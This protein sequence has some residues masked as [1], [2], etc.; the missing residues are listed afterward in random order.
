MPTPLPSSCAALL[1]RLPVR[2]LPVSVPVI[3]FEGAR[4]AAGDAVRRHARDITALGQPDH[5]GRA[6][7]HGQCPQG[8]MDGVDRAAGAQHGRAQLVHGRIGRVADD[9][10]LNVADAVQVAHPAC[11]RSARLDQ[12]RGQIACDL[13]LWGERLGLGVRDAGLR[14]AQ[15]Q[16][17]RDQKPRQDGSSPAFVGRNAES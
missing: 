3:G 4:G 13:G 17:Q 15:D 12:T 5:I 8:R 16:R 6:H 14:Q 10:R 9:D 1:L 11:F 7:L 2:T